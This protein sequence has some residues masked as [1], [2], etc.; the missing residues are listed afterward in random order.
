MLILSRKI[1]EALTIGETVTIAVVGHNGNQVRLG[2]TAPKDCRS[3]AQRFSLASSL[4]TDLQS[5][6]HLSNRGSGVISR[7]LGRGS[8]RVRCNRQRLC[9]SPVDPSYEAPLPAGAG[10]G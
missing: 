6:R 2:I 4:K 10:R 3:I 5:E 1:G 7:G 8:G 9:S